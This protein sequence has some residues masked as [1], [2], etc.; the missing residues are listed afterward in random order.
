[1]LTK[2]LQQ[3]ILSFIFLFYF[4]YS[5]SNNWRYP[6]G[7]LSLRNPVVCWV[8]QPEK[9][10]GR[11]QISHKEILNNLYNELLASVVRFIFFDNCDLKKNSTT[12]WPLVVRKLGFI[13]YICDQTFRPPE[14]WS[15]LPTKS[16]AQPT[17]AKK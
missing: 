1:M 5:P 9:S 12:F 7:F 16:F 10:D 11:C 14:R 2:Y 3:H 17:F 15:K 13:F 4:C 6:A 8:S